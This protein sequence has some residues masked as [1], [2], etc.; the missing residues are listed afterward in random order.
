MKAGNYIACD[1]RDVGNFALRY[2]VLE[3]SVKEQSVRLLGP[4]NEKTEEIRRW[5]QRT[6]YLPFVPFAAAVR[7]YSR[8]VMTECRPVPYA[9]AKCETSELATR[10]APGLAEASLTYS[11]RTPDSPYL[12]SAIPC[13]LHTRPCHLGMI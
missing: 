2:Q 13:M 8:F 9:S 10:K 5:V 6:G 3:W 1:E 4:N 7:L 11:P 12:H